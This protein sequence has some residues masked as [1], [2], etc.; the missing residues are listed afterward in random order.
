[1]VDLYET[2]DKIT[3]LL[4]YKD[5]LSFCGS[6]SQYQQYCDD[7]KYWVRKAKY[8]YNIDLRSLQLDNRSAQKIVLYLRKGNKYKSFLKAVYN[9]LQN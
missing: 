8:L 7:P 2:F 9:Y 5:T 1:M 3:I 4:G 6:H